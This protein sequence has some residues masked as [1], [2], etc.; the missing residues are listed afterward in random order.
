MK[1]SVFTI[2]ILLSLGFIYTG[3][4][5]SMEDNGVESGIRNVVTKGNWAV[6]QYISANQDQ[7]NDFAGYKFVFSSDGKVSVSSNGVTTEG[8]WSENLYSKRVI[9][10]F[11]TT[12]TVLNKINKE[13]VLDSQNSKELKFANGNPAQAE[14]LGIT[15]Q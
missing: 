2:A 4:R 12:N 9:L 5:T 15:Q 13:W 7:T 11:N 10:N 6:Y 1:R 14:V 3:C 8:V